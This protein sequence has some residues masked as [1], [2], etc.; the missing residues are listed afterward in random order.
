MQPPNLSRSSPSSVSWSNR[1]LIVATVAIFFLTLYPFEFDLHRHLMRPLFPFSLG[2]WGKGVDAL[3]DF[4]NVLLFLPLGF[5]LAESSRER[6][7]SRLAALALSL[8][9]GCSLSYVVELLQIYLPLR[10]SGWRDVLT[11]SIGAIFGATLFDLLGPAVVRQLSRA[12]HLASAWLTFGRATAV[13]L[14]YVGLWSVG[15]ACLQRAARPDNW[16]PD[17]FLVVGNSASNDRQSGWSGQ[18]YELDVWGRAVSPELA[19]TMTS[20]NAADA[21]ASNSIAVYRFSGPGPY[22]DE[23]HLL[24]NLSWTAQ[25]P[26]TNA[27]NDAPLNRKSWLVSAGS[28]SALVSDLRKTGQ[29]SVRVLCEPTETNGVDARIVS[30]LSAS[31]TSNLEMR[32]KDAS[33]VFWFRTPISGARSRMS[34]TV[35][36]IFAANKMCDILLSFDGASVNFFVDGGRR[37]RGYELGPGAALARYVRRIKAPELKGYRYIFYAIV[38]F[39]LGSILGLLWK[40]SPAPWLR[41]FFFLLLGLSPAIVLEFVLMHVS[42]RALSSENLLLSIVLT[43]GS[44]LW[45]NAD[46]RPP[47]TWPGHG[48]LTSQR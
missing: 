39:P 3:D 23:R 6:G 12:E 26:S 34:W 1:I 32:Q 17:S 8:L 18:V 15:A 22:P 31:G 42:G 38:F 27:V 10:D 19:L 20:Q 21:S 7:K 16:N 41:L 25:A 46:R 14:V 40:P 43:F 45:I 48:Q 5:G 11:N 37:G 30:I 35:P 4:L 29:F 33:L 24:P 44:S 47:R 2:G 9:V 28:V 13:L 36:E